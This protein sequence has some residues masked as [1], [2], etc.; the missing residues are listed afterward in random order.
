MTIALSHPL[1]GDLYVF[2]LP[3]DVALEWLVV[4]EHPDDP[5]LLLAAPADDFPLVG[6]PDVLLPRE[7]ARRPLTARCGETLWLPR[8]AFSSGIHAETVPQEVLSLVR[9]KL[10]KL[11]RGRASGSDEQ[12]QVDLD[13][14]Y[15]YWIGLVERCRDS[16]GASPWPGADD[17]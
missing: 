1:P 2:A 15:G 4:R 9:R 5:D 17:R 8:D 6:T 16:L 7:S 10:A 11:S 12:R 13:P 14:E 3:V